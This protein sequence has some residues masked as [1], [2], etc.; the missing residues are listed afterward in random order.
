MKCLISDDHVDPHPTQQQEAHKAA[1]VHRGVSA[2]HRAQLGERVREVAARG[3]AI[4]CEYCQTEI[5]PSNHSQVK[6]NY[7]QLKKEW[8]VSRL[9]HILP[10]Y[11]I[12]FWEA[13]QYRK[14]KSFCFLP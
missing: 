4:R 8:P 12:F 14:T 5:A 6:K 13:L 2:Q 3:R 11:Q 10:N 7:A 1:D 9:E